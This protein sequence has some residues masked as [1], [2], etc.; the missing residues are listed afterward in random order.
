MILIQRYIFK[1]LLYNFAFTFVVI[2]M[3]MLLA[4]AVKVIF[5]FPALGFL[6]LIKNIPIMLAASLTIVI[7]ASVLVAT[8]MTYGR[9]AS[10]NEI[11]TMR[12]SGIH[13]LRILIPGIIFG[14]I[15]SLTLLVIN[16]RIVPMAERHLKNVE[17][18]IDISFL[19]DMAL[20]SGEKKLE[21]NEWLLSWERCTKAES[22]TEG[23]PAANPIESWRF[24]GL[25]V[26]QFEE[27]RTTLSVEIWAESARIE[28][29][30]QGRKFVPCLFMGKF[31]YGKEGSFDRLV[32]PAFEFS[33][34]RKSK[35][36][37]SMRSL[38]ALAAMKGRSQKAYVD[39]KVETEL[40]KRIA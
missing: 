23:G 21:L 20:R 1:E 19:L 15:A 33:S 24:S 6:I 3:I 29:R 40:H 16:D 4:T 14:L 31:V 36:R 35:I 10:D 37:P 30:D 5:K 17:S 8:V 13:V 26:K 27:D 11:V 2:A 25:R 28:V 9:I 39:H 32:L 38:G 18:T 7:P 34:P 12:A 22:E